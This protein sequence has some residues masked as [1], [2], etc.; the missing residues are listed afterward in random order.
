MSV[1]NRE[2]R[3][4]IYGVLVAAFPVVAVF[5]PEILPAIPLWLALALA[6]LN[7]TPKDAIVE[8]MPYVDI[9][10]EVLARHALLSTAEQ[11]ADIQA[12]LSR[13]I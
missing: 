2:T 7:L 11:E 13:R 6:L 4:W 8:E 3:K 10:D 9:K 1:F 5:W 12:A